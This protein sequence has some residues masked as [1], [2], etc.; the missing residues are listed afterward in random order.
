MNCIRNSLHPSLWGHFV[1]SGQVQENGIFFLLSVIILLF[2]L[3][4]CLLIFQQ[5]KISVYRLYCLHQY[6]NVWI[7][8]IQ[9]SLYFVVSSTGCNSYYSKYF[10]VVL[11]DRTFLIWWL[12]IIIS[13]KIYIYA[14]LKNIMYLIMYLIM[15]CEIDALGITYLNKG[16]EYFLW[17]VDNVM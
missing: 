14:Q 17:R 16:C 1:H 8:S 13:T 10:C 4:T 15:L 12:L 9:S 6:K 11:Q 3:F 5:L 2:H 7:F